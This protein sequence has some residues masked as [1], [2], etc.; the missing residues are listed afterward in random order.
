[1]P[2][3]R[4]KVASKPRRYILELNRAVGDSVRKALR[5]FE[6]RGIPADILPH[7]TTLQITKPDNMPFGEFLRIIGKG[8]QARIGSVIMFSQTTGNAFI[9]NNRGN[10]PGKFFRVPG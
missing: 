1:M 3:T 2:K 7:K 9:C 10:R 5:Y 8:I 6:R 4:R